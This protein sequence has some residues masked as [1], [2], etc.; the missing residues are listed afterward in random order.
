VRTIATKGD[1][2]P[3]LVS[4]I[5]EHQQHLDDTGERQNRD[6]ERLQAE[7]DTLI[8]TNLVY[9]WRQHVSDS[10]YQ[11]ILESLIARQISPHQ[12]VEALLNGG[13][14]A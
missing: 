12:A 10:Q 6:R 3:E 1:G 2:L 9:R 5:S 11:E 4:A 7:L 8:Q 13:I 14:A